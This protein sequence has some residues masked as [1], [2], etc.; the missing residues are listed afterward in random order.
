MNE[1][2]CVVGNATPH[3]RTMGHTTSRPKRNPAAGEDFRR[4]SMA[5][6]AHM[7]A[8]GPFTYRDAQGR[9]TSTRYVDSAQYHANADTPKQREPP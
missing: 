4:R 7:D 5:R 3:T 2:G 6:K 8:A 9:P 1:M